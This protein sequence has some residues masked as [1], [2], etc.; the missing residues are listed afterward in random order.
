MQKAWHPG[1]TVTIYLTQSYKGE[2]QFQVAGPL[3][4]INK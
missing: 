2:S 3:A 4:S 1:S